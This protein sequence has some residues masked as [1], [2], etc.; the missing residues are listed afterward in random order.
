MLKVKLFHILHS[1]LDS[2]E[3][4]LTPVNRKIKLVSSKGKIQKYSQIFKNIFTQKTNKYLRINNFNLS[5]SVYVFDLLEKRKKEEKLEE[6]LFGL[7]ERENTSLKNVI[8]KKEKFSKTFLVHRLSDSRVEKTSVFPSIPS[9]PCFHPDI[10][11][12]AEGGK[13]W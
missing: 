1:N 13:Q 5:F 2:L 3:D 8:L 4:Y 9:F 11:R 12:M 10:P 6:K 7:D